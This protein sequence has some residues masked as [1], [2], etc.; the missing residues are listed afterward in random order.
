MKTQEIANFIAE[1]IAHDEDF[2]RKA[3]N[4]MRHYHYILSTSMHR[5]AD[6]WVFYIENKTDKPQECI[7]LR[8]QTKNSKAIKINESHSGMVYQNEKGEIVKD[9]RVNARIKKEALAVL[10]AKVRTSNAEQF[11]KA[12]YEW[13]EWRKDG[14]IQEAADYAFF[15]YISPQAYNENLID[16]Y[17]FNLKL[18]KDV[19]LKLTIYPKSSLTL[20]LYIERKQKDAFQCVS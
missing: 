18:T 14:K 7:L 9:E 15:N 1:K 19:S 2:F 4:F 12:G 17:D 16:I 3:E 10:N 13:L 6:T 8:N 11:L 5:N 20:I